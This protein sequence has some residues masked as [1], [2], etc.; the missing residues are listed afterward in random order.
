MVNIYRSM[1]A[2]INIIFTISMVLLIFRFWTDAGVTSRI[3]MVAGLLIFP[4]LQPLLIFLRS[5]KIVGKIPGDLEMT[6]N[7]TGIEVANCR[8]R[9]FVDYSEVKSVIW[10]FSM[11]I[12]YTR[13]KQ[14]FILDDEVLSDKGKNL[15]A[16]LSEKIKG[17]S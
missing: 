14:G 11:L 16:F 9:N 8:Q 10:I 7:Q 4:V 5:R 17:N 12:I 13:S 6:F 15:S 2:V 3:L 1:M